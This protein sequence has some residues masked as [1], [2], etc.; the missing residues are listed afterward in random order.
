MLG[1]RGITIDRIHHSLDK[2]L[3]RLQ[4]TCAERS[5]ENTRNKRLNLEKFGNRLAEYRGHLT[6]FSGG[7]PNT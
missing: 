7:V 6:A 3:T 5:A 2:L 1:D 4:F